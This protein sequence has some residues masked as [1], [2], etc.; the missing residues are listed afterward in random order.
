MHVLYIF[1]FKV[2]FT[3]ILIKLYRSFSKNYFFGR[4]K[5]ANFLTW[6]FCKKLQLPKCDSYSHLYS[7]YIQVVSKFIRSMS[8]SVIYNDL[9]ALLKSH[10]L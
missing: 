7:V 9:I 8:Y 10:S 6:E 3:Q 5:Y 2:I 1:I 4:M